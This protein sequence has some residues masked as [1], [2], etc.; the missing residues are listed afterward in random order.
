MTTMLEQAIREM[1]KQI[2]DEQRADE[3]MAALRLETVE[4]FAAKDPDRE[5]IV[6]CEGEVY[7]ASFYSPERKDFIGDCGTLGVNIA[8]AKVLAVESLQVLLPEGG[9]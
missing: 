1:Q 3:I 4:E 2:D 7:G 8:S 5:C 9:E 6:F